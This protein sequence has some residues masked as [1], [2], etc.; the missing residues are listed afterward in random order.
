VGQRPATVFDGSG[1]SAVAL[2]ACCR[3][4]CDESGAAPVGYEA[5]RPADEDDQ[6]ILEPD[7]IEEVDE[8]PCCPSNKAAEADTF[9]VRD[10]RRS[11][12]GGQV[13]FVAVTKRGVVTPS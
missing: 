6:P 8:Q 10:C 5:K 11:A 7:Q 12:D 2:P 9:D 13:A 1:R 3:S 4:G